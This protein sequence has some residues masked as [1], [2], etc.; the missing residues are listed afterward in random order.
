LVL[1][2]EEALV[3]VLVLAVESV[4]LAPVL[5]VTLWV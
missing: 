4:V 3:L 1:V 2:P 5:L